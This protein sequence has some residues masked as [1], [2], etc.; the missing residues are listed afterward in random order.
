[1]PGSERMVCDFRSLGVRANRLEERNPLHQLP[2]QTWSSAA[3]VLRAPRLSG[4]F[5]APS[6]HGPCT[7]DG[8][9]L[10]CVVR[11]P[12]RRTGRQPAS[13]APL[14]VNIGGGAGACP[15]PAPLAC[16]SVCRA[17]PSPNID[18]GG[19]RGVPVTSRGSDCLQSRGPSRRVCKIVSINRWAMS[20]SSPPRGLF[21]A[22]KW[23]PGARCACV[24][25]RT[26]CGLAAGSSGFRPY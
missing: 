15:T 23:G 9:N 12:Y 21:A 14:K 4:C 16:P 20:S 13:P 2:R 26:P 1:M 7:V 18:L 10:A 3:V 5:Q 22:V 6:K 8:K 25:E 24:V 19:S 17:P 11:G